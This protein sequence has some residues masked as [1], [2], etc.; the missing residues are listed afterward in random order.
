MF[1]TAAGVWPSS[2]RRRQSRLLGLCGGI[3]AISRIVT[4][5]LVLVIVIA[6]LVLLFLIATSSI[7]STF[8]ILVTGAIAVVAVSGVFSFDVVARL[9][10]SAQ[11]GVTVI[12]ALG[13][14][15]LL[16]VPGRDI[17]GLGS[18]SG[19]GRLGNR[20]GGGGGGVGLRRG[21]GGLRLLLAPRGAALLNHLAQN[22]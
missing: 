11:A 9:P 19:G 4:S 3:V 22:I 14:G 18:S 8:A 1:Y 10:V 7:S 12:L 13:S 5:L 20:L 17:L 15:R 16:S 2:T 6:T 21:H